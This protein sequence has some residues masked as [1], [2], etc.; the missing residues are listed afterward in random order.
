MDGS[1]R[2][3]LSRGDFS[4]FRARLTATG[5]PGLDTGRRM[6]ADLCVSLSP[7]QLQPWTEEARAEW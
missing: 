2:L 6:A 5:P 4:P 7:A 1:P 3:G